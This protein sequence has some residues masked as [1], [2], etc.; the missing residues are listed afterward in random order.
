[1]KITFHI[2]D[3]GEDLSFAMMTKQIAIFLV[4]VKQ[5]K[6]QLCMEIFAVQATFLPVNN[7]KPSRSYRTTEE[8]Q[9]L[10]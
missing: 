6:I 8:Q 2:K 4:G 7:H 9:N 5:V 10:F 1:L 3:V